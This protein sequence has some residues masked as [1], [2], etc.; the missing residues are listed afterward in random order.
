MFRNLTVVE[1]LRVFT[2]AGNER[3]TDVQE[4][5]FDRFPQL[6]E[7]RNQL[8]EPRMLEGSFSHRDVPVACHESP[9]ESLIQDVMSVPIYSPRPCIASRR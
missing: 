3:P 1:N 6:G 2:N 5:A 7:R 9:S 4:R 8:L